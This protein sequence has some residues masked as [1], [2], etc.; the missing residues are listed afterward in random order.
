[1]VVPETLRGRTALVGV[2]RGVLTVK[3]EDAGTKFELDRFLRSG[4]EAALVGRVPVGLR[5]VRLVL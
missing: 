4:G 2:S 5:R 1:V 3:V